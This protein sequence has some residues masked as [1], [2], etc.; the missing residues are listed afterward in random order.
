MILSKE[1]EVEQEE[2]NQGLKEYAMIWLKEDQ[3][4]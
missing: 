2:V 4:K 1:E 3:P